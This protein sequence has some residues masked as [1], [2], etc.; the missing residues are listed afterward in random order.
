MNLGDFF[1]RYYVEKNKTV[2]TNLSAITINVDKDFK[3]KIIQRAANNCQCLNSGFFIKIKED[4]GVSQKDIKQFLDSN[5]FLYK[6]YNDHSRHEFYVDLLKDNCHSYLKHD[7]FNE[8]NENKMIMVNQQ[9]YLDLLECRKRCSELDGVVNE[10]QDSTHCCYCYK[11]T[12]NS[13]RICHECYLE[14]ESCDKCYT[15]RCGSNRMIMWCSEHR[16]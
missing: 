1:S 7:R 3:F 8:S 15:Y 13:S 4:S 11:F 2:A 16:K 14:T 5:G 6:Q 10:N 9:E 12:S